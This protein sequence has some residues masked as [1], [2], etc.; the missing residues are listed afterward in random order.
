MLVGQPFSPVVVKMLIAFKKGGYHDFRYGKAKI[1]YKDTSGRNIENVVMFAKWAFKEEDSAALK[2]EAL[3]YEEMRTKG[4]I[5]GKI[6]PNFFGY[7]EAK[8]KRTGK[9]NF[10]VSVFEYRQDSPEIK[11]HLE[12]H[13]EVTKHIE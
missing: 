8:D 7:Y 9:I 10:A 6:T 1:N 11:S 4:D 3:L 12:E 5:L 2:K 13:A